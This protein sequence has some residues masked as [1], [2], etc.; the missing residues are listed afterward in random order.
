MVFQRH[1]KFKETGVLNSQERALLAA[2]SRAKQAQV[3]WVML[4][5]AVTGA[6]IGIPS[7]QTPN[8][9]QGK[10][11]MRWTSATRAI[12]TG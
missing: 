9:T 8:K 11:G 3:G 10:G 5:D 1:R 2:S 4:D 6:R 12:S 7:K